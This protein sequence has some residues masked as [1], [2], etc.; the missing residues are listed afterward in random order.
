MQYR[1]NIILY[2]NKSIIILYATVISTSVYN[3]RYSMHRVSKYY[4]AQQIWPKS[5]NKG[6]GQ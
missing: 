6:L 4:A 1:L 2:I 5:Y 3:G